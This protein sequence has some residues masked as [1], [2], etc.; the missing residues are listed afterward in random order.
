MSADASEPDAVA[1]VAPGAEVQTVLLR[2]P[3]DGT[4]IPITTAR[5]LSAAVEGLAN[6]HGPVAVDAERASG[7]R[8]SQRAYLVQLRRAGYGTVLIDPVSLPDLSAIDEALAEAEWILHA[9]NQDLACLSELGMRPRQLFDTELVGRLL[10]SERVALGTMVEQYLGVHLEKGH[11]A[12]DW[13]TRP[14]PSEWLDYAALDVELLIELRSVLHDELERAGKLAWAAEEFQAILD[15]PPPPP[16]SEP[17]R[18]ISGIHS[19]RNRRQLAMARS[20]WDARDRQASERDVAPGRILPDAAIVAAVKASPGSAEELATLP[21]FNGPRQ[22]RQSGYWF[23]ALDEGRRLEEQALPS[24]SAAGTDPDAMPAPARWRDRD[25]AAAVRLAAVKDVVAK[26][27]AKH[28]VVSQNL[29]AGEVI[30][31]LAWRGVD[32]LGEAAVR[33]RLS[34][35]GGRRWQI[36]LLAE[37]LTVALGEQPPSEVPTS[38]ESPNEQAATEQPTSEQPTSEPPVPNAGKPET[39]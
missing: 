33:E 17:W 20:M 37:P 19:M 38:D 26:A 4:P 11:S 21:I 12:A 6:A 25:P 24:L 10:G 39:S 18:R 14:L 9:A 13:S 23:R 29:L 2:T 35:L 36:D 3:R 28:H 16:R 7:Y 22:R 34:E 8:Y 30:R 5:Q 1:G 15:A 31:R 32:P 27:A